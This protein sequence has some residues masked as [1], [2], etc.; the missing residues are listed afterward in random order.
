MPCGCVKEKF[1]MRFIGWKDGRLIKGAPS[2]PQGTI[3]AN[4][5]EEASL[6]HWVLVEPLPAI[7]KVSRDKLEDSVYELKETEGEDVDLMTVKTL[8]L[9]IEFV[10]SI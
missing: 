3:Q 9:F 7:K 6:P 1:D 8:K 5:I 4:F 2:L 10:M